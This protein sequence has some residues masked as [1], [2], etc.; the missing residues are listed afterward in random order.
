MS[1][2][3]KFT[4]ALSEDFLE[5]FSELP[6]TQMKKVKE[7]ISKFKSNPTSSGINYE[8]IIQAKDQNMKSVRIDQNYR[9][10]IYK[11][12]RGNV[13]ILLWVAHHD[14]AYNWCKRKKIELNGETGAIQI[15]EIDN[16]NENMKIP[17]DINALFKGLSDKELTSLGVPNVL[18]NVVRAIVDE[19]EYKQLRGKFPLEVRDALDFYLEGE[20]VEDIISILYSDIDKANDFETALKHVIS[21]Q[22]FIILD[23]DNEEELLKMLDE[24]LDKWRVF[25]HKS[26]RELVEKSFSGPTRILGGAGTG[27]TVV[28][29]HRAKHLA[30]K[31]NP[32][33]TDRILL[34]T[35]NVNLAEDIKLNLSKIC[36]EELLRKIDVV[37]LDRWAD[38]TLKSLGYKYD[39]RYGNDLNHIWEKAIKNTSSDLK[40]EFVKREYE[41]VIIRNDI[42]TFEQYRY[43]NR[44]GTEKKISQEDKAVL[45]EVIS[46]YKILLNENNLKDIYSVINELRNLLKNREYTSCYSSIIVDEAQDFS[47]LS[48]KLIKDLVKTLGENSIFICGDT[49]Q[50]IYAS[51]VVLS[52]C[53]I[54]IRGRSYYLKIN[55][56]TPEETR[57]WASCILE[58]ID[59]DDLDTEQ[60]ENKGY[61]SLIFGEVP[62]IQNYENKEEEK[63][64]I[65]NHISHLL[66]SGYELK[67]ICLVS[68][69]S[70]ILNSYKTSLKEANIKYYELKSEKEDRAID[71]IRMAT[72][73]RVKGL[74][75]EHM[76]IVCMNDSVFP[77]KT[78][79]AD[80]NEHEN[81]ERSLL[82]VAATRT[83][84]TLLVTSYGVPSQVLEWK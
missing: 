75:F 74:E 34:T 46:Q 21:R 81:L 4:V 60:Y 37:N 55:Y 3:C 51:K 18:L 84:R 33:S 59:F 16:K 27:K 64:G 58:N 29:I 49:K 67:D 71:G 38:D 69:T 2:N 43:V 79:S 26:Q 20:S 28:A 9:G 8:N 65:L 32:L 1:L 39:L 48:F 83:K 52:E 53:G 31:L 19:E 54:K 10:I 15:F 73:H 80:K 66:N 41:D 61:K 45:W 44:I 62:K 42:E 76:I 6:K 7:F 57:K 68:R 82:Y 63:K 72:M 77:L 22:R 30:S 47:N 12:E 5:S 17:S 11:P 13:Y 56:R 23:D 36:S 24:P 40:K 70:N 14:D 35:F 50:R 78:T 25:L